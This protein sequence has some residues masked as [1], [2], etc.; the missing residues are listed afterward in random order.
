MPAQKYKAIFNDLEDGT[1]RIPN[2]EI[3]KEWK[4]TIESV[5]G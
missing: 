1:C 4:R 2:N 3:R 5:Y